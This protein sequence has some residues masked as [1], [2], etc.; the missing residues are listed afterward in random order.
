MTKAT[1]PPSSANGPPVALQDDIEREQCA[2]A[3]LAQVAVREAQD[4]GTDAIIDAVDAA[5]LARTEHDSAHRAADVAAKTGGAAAAV[6]RWRW[7]LEKLSQVRWDPM[8]TVIPVLTASPGAGA[9]VV[10]AAL[11]DALHDSRRSVMLIDAADPVRSGL[12]RAV[13]TEGAWV[14]GP[15]P[16]V[17][18]R[19]SRRRG[20][21]VGRVD[22]E[23][24]VM[25]PGM[26]PSPPWWRLLG[27]RHDATVVD[28]AHDAWRVAANPLVGAGAW[29]RHGMP[30]PRPI[31]VCQPSAPSLLSAEAVLAR[32][33]SWAAVGA[34]APVERLVVVGARRWPRDVPGVAG[35]RLSTLVDDAVFVPHDPTIAAHGITAAITPARIRNALRPVLTGLRLPPPAGPMRAVP[36]VPTTETAGREANTA[37]GADGGETA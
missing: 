36:P 34:L 37:L 22:T 1:T 30:S 19:L 20:V 8:G 12:S 24:P 27:V 32:L 21:L 31:L 4:V 29:M 11:A 15:H 33:D 17:R 14:R 18:I 6:H 28:I 5:T 16:L 35:R 2:Q 3:A 23:L 26:V 9:S 13:R 10:A 7:P 25:S